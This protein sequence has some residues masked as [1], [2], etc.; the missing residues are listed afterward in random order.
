MFVITSIYNIYSWG[1]FPFGV[2]SGTPFCSK[3]QRKCPS[4]DSARVN[5]ITMQATL[6][7]LIAVLMVTRWLQISSPANIWN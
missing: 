4:V 5:H 1:L 2:D 7:M 3:R 6:S